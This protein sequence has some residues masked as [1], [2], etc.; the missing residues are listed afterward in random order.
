MD[1]KNKVNEIT[2]ESTEKMPKKNIIILFSLLL[3]SLLAVIY[4]IF[5]QQI[6]QV[7]VSSDVSSSDSS[8]ISY[9]ASKDESSTESKEEIKKFPLGVKIHE[10]D[11]SGMTAEEAKQS[12]IQNIE[13]EVKLETA[14]MIK[15]MEQN[16]K[17]EANK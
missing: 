1:E 8:E 14:V 3:V 12:L 5:S 13:H 2:N 10:T 7:D 4:I 15:T 16:A 6:P 9:E 11:V 17:E